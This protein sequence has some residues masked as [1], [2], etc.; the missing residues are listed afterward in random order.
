[1]AIFQKEI[2]FN[3]K[4]AGMRKTILFISFV[5]VFFSIAIP[6]NSAI[7]I[8]PVKETVDPENTYK[9]IVSLKIKD[10]QKM[11]GRKLTL[12]EKISFLILRHQLKN[13][14]DSKPN[15]G[16]TA[17]T[18]GIFGVV[19]FIAGLFFAPLLVGSLI[20]AILAVVLG[21]LARKENSSDKKALA[22]ILMG[23]IT[24]GLIALLLI[25]AAIIVATWS[26][27]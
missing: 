11:I 18:F 14:A 1:M 15:Q 13:H 24:L 19:L 16:K 8:S 23:W 4:P 6:V 27:Y 17:M 2:T 21:S 12:K 9:K 3:S 10:V 22:V 5:A 26:W 25:L 20:A 7:I